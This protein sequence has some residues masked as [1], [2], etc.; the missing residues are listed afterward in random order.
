MEEFFHIDFAF[1]LRYMVVKVVLECKEEH[2]CIVLF[3][4]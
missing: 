2:I 1:S 4:V 3:P